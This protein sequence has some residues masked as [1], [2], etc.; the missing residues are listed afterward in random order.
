MKLTQS[1]YRGAKAAQI[2]GGRAGNCTRGKIGPPESN[3]HHLAY[4]GP[5]KIASS[6]RGAAGGSYPVSLLYILLMVAGDA[7]GDD[8]DHGNRWKQSVNERQD[9]R[10]PT[11]IYTAKVLHPLD[12][13]YS[14]KDHR[15]MASV[16][17]TW[18]LPGCC[19]IIIEQM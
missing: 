7:D 13:Q 15:E 18:P 5:N 16:P 6:K 2:K 12:L 1:V 17:S 4:L 3:Y 10:W 14:A 9:A 8:S 11:Q 19:R